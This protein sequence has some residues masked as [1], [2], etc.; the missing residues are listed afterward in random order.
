MLR[1]KNENLNISLNCQTFSAIKKG[2]N[3]ISRNS[4]IVSLRRFK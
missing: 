3:K 1:L 4:E 2:I